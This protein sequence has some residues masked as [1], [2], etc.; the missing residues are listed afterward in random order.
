M[1]FRGE[2]DSQSIRQLGTSEPEDLCKRENFKHSNDELPGGAMQGNTEFAARFV[3]DLSYESIPQ[4]VLTRAKRQILDIIGVALAGS[5][6]PVG[7]LAANFVQRTGGTSESTLWG[8]RLRSSAPQAAFAN[9]VF[10]HATDYDDM[11]LPGAHPTGVTFPAAFSM[12]EAVHASGRQLLVSQVAGYEIMGKLHAC[13]DQRGGWHPTP[14]FGTFGATAA[15]AKLLGLD[16]LRLQMAF[17]IAASEASGISLQSGTMTKPFHSGHAAR[18][19]VVAAM[20]AADGFSAN[21]LVLDGAFFETFF[22][23]DSSGHWLMTAMLGS[24]YHLVTPGIGIKMYPSGYHLHHSF[25]AAL[26]LVKKHNIGVEDVDSVELIVPRRGHF[27]RPNVRTGLEGKFSYQYHVAMA[28][29]DQ[30]LTIESFHDERALARDVQDLLKKMT[31]RVDPAIPRNPDIVYYTI[32][33]KLRDGK[34]VSAA[35]PLPR[36]HWR[37]PLARDE[38]VG[39][40]RSNAARV[41]K[42]PNIEKIIDAV[43]KLEDL[44]DVNALT[45]LLR[46]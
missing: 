43:D 41:L 45:E 22:G 21:P 3:T 34:E 16:P 31:V 37:Y 10:S 18:N 46:Q 44:S 32:A 5:T 8:T 40:F 11:W 30:K 26:E 42:E 17:G 2:I 6:Q 38:W 15:V 28:I 24:P 39:K 29:L 19:G 33:I 7:K 9:G 25:E 13:V 14:V 36:S 20:L 1:S 23:K 4:E 12:A 35:Q 27:D